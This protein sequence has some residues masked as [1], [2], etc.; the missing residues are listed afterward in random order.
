MPRPDRRSPRPPI[1]GCPG[2]IRG[3]E[4][5]LEEKLDELHH[6]SFGSCLEPTSSCSREAGGREIGL[7]A[8]PIPPGRGDTAGPSPAAA[9]TAAHSEHD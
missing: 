7:E 4:L 3:L 1:T 8:N 6:C 5:V 2:T 9:R